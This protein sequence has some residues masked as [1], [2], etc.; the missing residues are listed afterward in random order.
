MRRRS[1]LSCFAAALL[2]CLVLPAAAHA[3]ANGGSD[4]M[5]CS[6]GPARTWYF[7]EGTTRPGFTEYVC[8][9]NPGASVAATEFDYMLPGGRTISRSHDLAPSSRTTINV[10]DEVPAGSDVSIRMKSSRPVVAERPM[11]FRYN[12]V[13]DGGH[14]VVGSTAPAPEWYFA[15]GTTRAGFD[16]Y[17]CLQ[18][19]GTADALVRLDYF[20]GDG[21]TRTRGGVRVEA[22][23]RFTVAVHQ[24]GL[25]IGRHNDESG[26]FSVKVSTA[27]ET[28]LVAERAMYFN[29]K[30]Y[31]TGGHVVVGSTA[32]APEW[33]FAEG[34]T[35]AGFDT[36]LCVSNP[37]KKDAN[38]D[39]SYYRG[40]GRQVE[41]V[42]VVVRAGSR[43]TVPVH[44]EPLG[45]GRHDDAGGDF[46]ARVRSTNG[47]PIVVE[48]SSYFFYR[49][50]WSGGHDVMGADGPMPEWHFAEG[51]T[52]Q[53][54]DTYLC[55]ANPSGK[56]AV[57][58]I[59]YYRGDNQV[60]T[61]EG[62]EVEAKS[63]RTVA[64]HGVAEG[65][66]RR[67][68]AGG[69]VSV[70]V[71]TA[72]GVPVIAERPMYFAERWRTMDR[73]AIA[74]AWG[75]GDR[76][77]GSG[78][79]PEV[80]VTIDCEN[81]AN[82]DRLMDILQQKGFHATFFLLDHIATSHPGVV[83]RM[84]FDG[85]E[86]GNHGVTHSRFTKLAPAQVAWELDTVEGHVN[87]L[88]GFTTKPYFRF[89]YGERSS[90]LVS[91][92]NGLGYFSMYW[93]VDP[94]EWRDSNTVSAVVNNV[95]STS[96]PGAI[97]L[98]HDSA[99]TIAALPSI[100]DGLAARGL[101]PVTLT[102]L[103]FPGP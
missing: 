63:R 91:R 93:S 71:S 32:P 12:G 97:I 17:L 58:S 48:R 67:D 87:A 34:T 52:R 95:V 54:F 94:Q 102:E 20:L 79:R 103:M 19:P 51:C 31:L 90:G 26:D 56:K 89:P 7:A 83:T 74:G 88:T 53:G 44:E 57:V 5:G 72:N 60:D 82:A 25:G 55:L 28:P 41:K 80:A 35:R 84:A 50:F 75:W 43:L 92:V 9:L 62:I 37:G 64:V 96:G 40:D 42:G 29:C 33:Y 10:N 27:G 30:P 11:Y 59:R 66:G 70:K 36:Y 4:V 99:K 18:N 21:T 45:I 86:I 47:A 73:A 16:S 6:T 61:R 15:E 65:T 38:V 68:D 13:W 24:E 3:A 77:R 39:V 81:N 85:H 2:C 22:A 78:R 69:D 100:L 8:V 46:S 98:M 76:A 23:S 14:V 49:P 1:L 101:K